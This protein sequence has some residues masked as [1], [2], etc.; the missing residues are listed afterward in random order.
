MEFATRPCPEQSRLHAFLHRLVPPFH[1]L[2][3][4]DK[5]IK[6]ST[7]P[8]KGPYN[9]VGKGLAMMELRSVVARTVNEF[10]VSVPDQENFD[11]KIF[12]AGIKDHFTSGI[13]DCQ[14]QF[15]RRIEA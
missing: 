11:E 1:P 5:V 6:N 2:I 14:I 15:T 3:D 8:F 13:P 12:Y 9:C 4:K 7:Y 10:D